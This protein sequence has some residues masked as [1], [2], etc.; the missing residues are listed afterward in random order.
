MLRS[1]RRRLLPKFVTTK[2]RESQAPPLRV[3]RRAPGPAP[4]ATR[5]RLPRFAPL[6]VPRARRSKISGLLTGIAGKI[7][8]KPRCPSPKP[9]DRAR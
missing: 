4:S 8:G 7:K 6:G 3:P 5:R 1:A 2:W 9:E